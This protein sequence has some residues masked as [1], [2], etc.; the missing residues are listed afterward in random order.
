MYSKYINKM[1]FLIVFLLIVSFF[2]TL[3]G[4]SKI[5][6]YSDIYARETN[7]TYPYNL[8]KSAQEYRPSSLWQQKHAIFDGTGNFKTIQLAKPTNTNN[9]KCIPFSCP[10]EE[11]FN[12]NTICWTCTDN[13]EYPMMYWLLKNNYR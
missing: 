12:G 7:N 10:N 3:F 2:F 9:K 1:L 13:M 11:R 4:Y 8:I 5:E 6:G